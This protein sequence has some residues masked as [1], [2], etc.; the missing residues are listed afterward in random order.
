ML[1]LPRGADLYDIQEMVKR[2]SAVSSGCE[3]NNHYRQSTE[4]Q[5]R[6]A[7]TGTG[8]QVDVDRQTHGWRDRETGMQ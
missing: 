6:R 2:L 3:V 8:R 1:R 7:G 5:E 4:R